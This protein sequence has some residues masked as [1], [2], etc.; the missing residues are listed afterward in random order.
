MGVLV[1]QSNPRDTIMG[2][3]KIFE[4]FQ[5]ES[6]HLQAGLDKGSTYINLFWEAATTFGWLVVATAAG[7]GSWAWAL[8][9]VV[10]MVTFDGST[11]NSLCSFK[12]MMI[13]DTSI[14]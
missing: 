7:G 11:M 8:S 3:D 12:K 10:L 1:S 13:G 14:V 4:K 6:K 2:E 5:Y 9:Y